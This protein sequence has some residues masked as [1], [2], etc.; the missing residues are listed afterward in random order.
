MRRN[1][2]ADGKLPR[3]F[4]LD[5]SRFDPWRVSPL[6]H[7]LCDHAL[8]RQDQLVA[9]GARLESRRSVRTHSGEA[10]AGTPFGAATQLHPNKLGAQKTLADIEHANA[11]MSLLNVQADPLYRTLVDEVL[12]D[13]QPMVERHDP[14]MCYRAGWIFVTS[15]NAVTPFHMD[16]EH[17]FI[18]Q[19]RGRKTLYVWEPHDTV[20]T[21]EEAR[22]LF[23]LTHSREL[24]PWREEARQR[25]HVFHLEPGMGA[26]MPSTSPHMVENGDNGSVTVSFTYYT[27]ATRRDSLLHAWHQRL[28]N[29]GLSP[30]P[31]G[32]RPLADAAAY[33]M[34]CAFVSGKRLLKQTLG[35]ATYP[36][37]ARYAHAFV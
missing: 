33:A 16:K 10:T 7:R 30:A 3:L 28:R 13:L 36:D 15:P 18:L 19:I 34:C 9:L 32:A 1:D 26:Y 21:S 37:D 22:D 8:L 12:D 6:T 2:T 20:V 14:G 11:W 31:V 23:H 17:N 27:D 4:D 5:W 24:A 25:A 35:R 29:R